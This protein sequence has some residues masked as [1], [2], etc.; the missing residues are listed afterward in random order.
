M[1]YSNKLV[2]MCLIS[3]TYGFVRG[4]NAQ[5]EPPHDVIGDK[6]CLSFMNG[7]TYGVPVYTPYYAIKLINRI[8]IKLTG[9]DPLKHKGDYEDMFCINYN[10]FF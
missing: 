6:V 9:K 4:M 3:F 10:T 8:D 7:M 5:Y 2:Y 1:A